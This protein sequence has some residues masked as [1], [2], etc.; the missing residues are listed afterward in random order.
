MFEDVYEKFVRKVDDASGSHGGGEREAVQRRCCTSISCLTCTIASR[1]RFPHQP[2]NIFQPIATFDLPTGG[3]K[4]QLL[5]IFQLLHG[6]G[7]LENTKSYYI[8]G[9]DKFLDAT[10]Q[11]GAL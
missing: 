6:P 5:S 8:T 2:N 3:S 7:H 10:V 1:Q 9:I 4:D 11:G